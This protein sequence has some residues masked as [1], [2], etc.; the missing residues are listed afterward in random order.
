MPIARA[1]PTHDDDD[2][3]DDDGHVTETSATLVCAVR[4]RAL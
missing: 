1:R 4:A 2:D 3:D